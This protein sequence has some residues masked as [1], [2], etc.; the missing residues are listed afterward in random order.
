MESILVSCQVYYTCE[1][2]QQ[3]QHSFVEHAATKEVGSTTIRNIWRRL[4][5]SLCASATTATVLLA[6]D[7]PA[8]ALHTTS[9]ENATGRGATPRC[10]SKSSSHA[11]RGFTGLA[12]NIY[13]ADKSKFTNHGS[14]ETKWTESETERGGGRSRKKES[15]RARARTRERA[16]ERKTTSHAYT[17]ALLPLSA[18]ADRL[19][20]AT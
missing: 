13:P 3:L 19:Y 15:A 9:A 6:A 12:F 7:G 11:R 2:V 16:H 4:K 10:N 8:K 5:G 17:N 18:P 1:H 14:D 20:L